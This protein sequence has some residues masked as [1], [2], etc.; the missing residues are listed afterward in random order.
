MYKWNICA[1]LIGSSNGV[2]GSDTI[3]GTG[4][5]TTRN[6]IDYRGFRIYTDTAKITNIAYTLYDRKID[7]DNAFRNLTS[8]G[9]DSADY[10]TLAD[11]DERRYVVVATVTSSVEVDYIGVTPLFKKGVIKLLTK[12]GSDEVDN[13]DESASEYS[14]ARYKQQDINIKV[15][16][17]TELL[18][19]VVTYYVMR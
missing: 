3:V 19:S 15:N 10:I 17:N 13:T 16:K 2:S 12:V 5:T 8:I 6:Y 14:G 18:E 11:D 1:T 9:V 7:K 4:E